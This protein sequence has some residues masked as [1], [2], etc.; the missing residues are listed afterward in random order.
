MCD[1]LLG[2]LTSTVLKRK[3]EPLVPPLSVHDLY[4]HRTLKTRLLKCNSTET[5]QSLSGKQIL[6]ELAYETQ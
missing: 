3:K 5:A 6:P 1:S 2:L 4:T